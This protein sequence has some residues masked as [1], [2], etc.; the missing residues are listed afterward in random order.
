MIGSLFRNVFHCFGFNHFA[1][2]CP[3]IKN[4]AR[5]AK[6]SWQHK[7]ENCGS[8]FLNC[9]NCVK[10]KV[11]GSKDREAMSRFCPILI[12]EQNQIQ[13]RTNY[14]HEKN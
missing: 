14:S 11:N 2:N 6:C 12:K 3:K 13:R 5:C 8:K 1:N 4:P 7:T 9:L 10:A